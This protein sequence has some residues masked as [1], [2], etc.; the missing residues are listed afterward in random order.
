[1]R[2]A[3]TLRLS[4]GK[5]TVSYRAD[6]VGAS[7]A[8]PVIRRYVGSVP[9]TRAYWDVTP[10]SSDDEFIHEAGTHPVFRLSQVESLRP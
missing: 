9:I 6:E 4:R 10:T 8:G 7:E 2:A 1:M 5:H 3:G